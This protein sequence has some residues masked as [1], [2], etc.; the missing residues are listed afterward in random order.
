MNAPLRTV[1]DAD[2]DAAIA[3]PGVVVV[4]FT[5]SWCQPC[6]RALPEVAG[7]AVDLRRRKG[8]A[9]AVLVQADID[10]AP[11]AANRADVRGVPCLVLFRDGSRVA[12]KVGFY[13][14]EKLLGWVET[15][16]Q[17]EG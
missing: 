11:Q 6:A 2:F 16:M 13:P 14:R 17:G 9:G 4:H 1:T 15:T 5:A 3:A 12:S 10:A 7:L 8:F